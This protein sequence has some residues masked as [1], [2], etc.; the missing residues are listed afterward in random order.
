MLFARLVKADGK[1]LVK[2]LKLEGI[3]GSK[4]NGGAK[5]KVLLLVQ[6][7]LCR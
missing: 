1:F 2:C 5:C 3:Q 4:L 7:A 6:C